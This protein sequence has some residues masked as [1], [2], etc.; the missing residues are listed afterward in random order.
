MAIPKLANASGRHGGTMSLRS[1]HPH[2][3]AR[4]SLRRWQPQRLGPQRSAGADY[5]AGRLGAVGR[6]R[7]QVGASAA[8]RRAARPARLSALLMVK[9]LLLREWLVRAVGRAVGSGALGPLS[10]SAGLVKLRRARSGRGRAGPLDGQPLPPWA[11]G[12]ARVGPAAVRRAQRSV[13]G[14]GAGAQAGHAAGRHAGRGAGPP[15]PAQMRARARAAS[16]TGTPAGRARA[17]ART[18]AIRAIS[19]WTRV[20]AW[21]AGPSCTRPTSNETEVADGLI[22]GDEQAVY[23]DRADEDNA[24]RRRLRAAG[25]KDRIK[26]RRHKY[27]PQLPHWQRRRNELIERRRAACVERVFGTLK[28]HY[29]TAACAISD[30]NATRSNCSSSASPTTS[31][32]PIAAQ[33]R[34]RLKRR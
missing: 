7:D 25:V 20:R 8:R 2:P 13:G 34:A 15:A 19:A 21:S 11:A 24:R 30:S 18:S 27:L 16:A 6:D 26:H 29:G 23:A 33:P 32:A 9:A 14:A 4:R 28:Q 3:A 1:R 22:V 31:D 12:A 5:G 10:H 17:G